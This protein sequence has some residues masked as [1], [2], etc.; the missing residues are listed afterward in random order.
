M[1][2]Y[3]ALLLYNKTINENN[4]KE[5]ID[6]IIKLGINIV[7]PT[8]EVMDLAISLALKYDITVYDAYFLALAQALDFACVIVEIPN[9]RTKEGKTF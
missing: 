3:L 1:F 9:F 5:A 8:K 6:S 2:E 7:V 4:V